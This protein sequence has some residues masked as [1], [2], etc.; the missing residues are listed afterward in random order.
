MPGTLEVPGILH[1]NRTETLAL[2]Q[3][4][5]GLL[6]LFEQRAVL[7]R[8]H[9]RGKETDRVEPAAFQVVYFVMHVRCRRKPCVAAETKALAPLD[10]TARLDVL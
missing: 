6:R 3:R 4:H 2:V 10:P 8:R 5:R 9:A 7:L 1:L